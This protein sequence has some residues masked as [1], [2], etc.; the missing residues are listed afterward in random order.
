MKQKM[1]NGGYISKLNYALNL[2]KNK[3]FG[4]VIFLNILLLRNTMLVQKTNLHLSN[5]HIDKISHGE[6]DQINARNIFVDI[7]QFLVI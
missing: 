3:K 6:G 5:W 2:R 1:H 4:N 7:F